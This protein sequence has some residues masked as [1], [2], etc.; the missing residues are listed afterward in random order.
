MRRQSDDMSTPT[1]LFEY[2]TSLGS[3]LP[4]IAARAT[5]Y[6]AQGLG[7]AGQY[8]G[9]AEQN[10]RLLAQLTKQAEP[11]PPNTLE[12]AEGLR[13]QYKVAGG[14]IETVAYYR[15]QMGNAGILQRNLFWLNTQ[16]TLA[17]DPSW[18]AA[19]PASMNIWDALVSFA[20][21]RLDL[22][23]FGPGSTDLPPQS[24]WRPAQD[25]NYPGAGSSP[26]ID[27]D[28]I[29]E[30]WSVR[31]VNISEVGRMA[32]DAR[33]LIVN[34]GRDEL[35]DMVTRG[36]TDQVLD[37]VE[38]RVPAL[39]LD[40]LMSLKESVDSVMSVKDIVGNFQHDAFGYIFEGIDAIGGDGPGPDPDA[41]E[42]REQRFLGELA[43]IALSRFGSVG[44]TVSKAFGFVR[45]VFERS[46]ARVGPLSL[47][48]AAASTATLE[49]Y[50]FLVQDI[51]LGSALVVP[52]GRS[53]AV[54]AAA[55]GD[56]VTGGALDDMLQGQGGVDQLNGGAGRDLLLGG[57]GDDRLMGGTGNDTL[58]GG[59]GDDRLIGALSTLA[60][61]LA[62]DGADKL[63]GGAGNDT[64]WGNVGNDSLFGGVDDDVLRGD[65]GDDLIDGGPGID[66][67][68]YHFDETAVLPG[69]LLVAIRF[70][71]S[72]VGGPG[73]VRF[74]DGL[75]GFD[76]LVAIEGVSF[77]GNTL[78]DTF[79]GSSGADYA[80]GHAGDDSLSGQ[81][82]N[83]TLEGG[84]GNDTLDGGDGVD[85]VQFDYTD[86][87]IAVGSGVV[88]DA[89]TLG[90]TPGQTLS[91]TGL[92][93]DSLRNIEALSFFGSARGD[94]VT[95]S[96]NGDMLAG[97]EGND[98]LDGG[99]G[100]DSVLGGG[101]AD[102]LLGG[103]GD[104]EL[105]GAGGNDTLVGGAGNDSAMFSG[106]L[107]D[108]SVS[109]NSSTAVFTLSDTVSGRD[110]VD[111]VSS[112]ERFAFADITLP[113]SELLP[114]NKAPVGLDLSASVAED[115][116]LWLYLPEASDRDGDVVSYAKASDPAHGT[117]VVDALGSYRYTPA[118]NYHGP[119][120]FSYTVSDGKGGQRSYNA[121]ITVTPVD[122][123]PVLLRPIPD[124]TARSTRPF[125]LTLPADTMVDVEGAPVTYAVSLGDGRVL[126][127][128]LRF[129]ATT[130][131]LAGTPGNAD[132]G[133][134]NLRVS[135]S[136][137]TT[138]G[139]DVFSLQVDLFLNKPPVAAG[140]S[141]V[142]TEDTPLRGRLP[143]ARDDDGDSVSYLA[144]SAPAH[145]ALVVETD[146]SYAYTPATD[147]FG[148]DAFSFSVMDPYGGRNS[149]AVQLQVLPVNDAPSG[150]VTVS[151]TPL[152]G[153]RLAA[154]ALLADADGLGS[155]SYQWLRGSAPIGGAN[156]SIYVPG[157]LDVGA[158]LSVRVSYVDAGGTAQSVI[159]DSSVFVVALG[160]FEGSAAADNVRGSAGPDAMWGF[161]G[162]DTLAGGAGN[163]TLDGGAGDDELLGGEGFDIAT[164]VSADSPVVADLAQGFA[165][166]AGQR[167]RLL[168]IEGLYGGKAAD[169]LRGDAGPNL[170]DGFQGADLLQGRDGAD[171]LLGSGE[172]DTLDGGAGVDWA[173][174]SNASTAATLSLSAGTAQFSR[175][176]TQLIGIENLRGTPYAD[177]LL[178]TAAGEVLDGHGGDDRL[179]AGAGDDRLVGGEG[180]DT[181][182]GGDGRDIADYRGHLAVNV[183]LDAGVARQGAQTDAL[184]SIEAVFGSATHDVLS[185][186]AGDPSRAG[187]VFRGGGGNDTIDGRAGVDRAEFGGPRNAY[188]IA[189]DTRE[190]LALT[191]THQAGGADGVDSLRDVELLIFSD[192][193][194]GFGLR[195]EQVARVATVLW[196]PAILASRELLAKG[197]SFYDVG[198]SY[199]ELCF[200][201]LNYWT[202]LSNAELAQNLIRNAGST[203]HTAD[204]LLGLMSAHGGAQAGRAQ[205]VKLLA[206]DAGTTG[207]LTLMGVFSQGVEASLT[208]D[209]VS[210]F[211]ALPG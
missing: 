92:G 55:N 130:R 79:I 171:T 61:P 108:Y 174:F 196:T 22:L 154:L 166:V 91:A 15:D 180:N 72:A 107:A 201:A 71:A 120:A 164:Y 179:D 183:D 23:D 7:P 192:R 176:T 28:P 17:D 35:G 53:V 110:G 191:V 73:P 200:V 203:R 137:G 86:A 173:D 118:L 66:R 43:E 186:R 123:A 109:Y 146:G 19:L 96:R 58:Y 51:G 25:A 80:F 204:E 205:A 136:D 94:R 11:E 133:T 5:L 188:A 47:R 178:G 165:L 97:A 182:L 198:Y 69:G 122:D 206:D 104:D 54:L 126:P 115:L 6:E 149:Y 85:M 57:A 144:A 70:D 93:Q 37:F 9:T 44:E 24:A 113:A 155:F 68:S 20:E 59:S 161:A 147:Y 112:V 195:A 194:I 31:G 152:E 26:L 139:A 34:R 181:L 64:L 76:M 172:A 10:T 32:K 207:T 124:Q 8:K 89:S 83:D 16:T 12:T 211:A 119:D 114:G 41:V 60:A 84:Y 74:A 50:R 169:T 163:D 135:G 27:I 187:E 75:G 88:I 127:A 197:L 128:W 45:V 141:V 156:A 99:A 160:A 157:G 38:D 21:R 129:D 14:E 40:S 142:A 210:L 199:D 3:K 209:G 95:G 162:A 33:E 49:T 90:G 98:T 159:S 175:D 52:S 39:L 140:T 81:G 65:Q 208:A 134:L 48:E 184:V 105:T 148:A 42:A 77:T 158:R 132:V 168:G 121:A 103:D 102:S 185:G 82:G 143:L 63:D 138:S 153:E 46:E 67:A 106:A 116:V 177:V 117:L 145:G 167:D 56:T 1:T 87:S 18:I 125:T 62:G 2:Y 100:N 193:V 189:R 101:G 29:T 202:S 150:S 111:V 78:G 151:G 170:I 30:D 131:T 36:V 190:P 13:A 4:S